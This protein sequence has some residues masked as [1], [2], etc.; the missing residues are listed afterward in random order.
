M[1]LLADENFP[2]PAVRALRSLGHDVAYAKETMR[3]APDRAVLRSAQAEGRV[4][5]TC[6]KDFGELAFAARL[7]A[8]CGVILFRLGGSSPSQ[9]NERMVRV[10]TGRDDWAGNF[11]VVTDTRVR[12]RP[13]PRRPVARENKRGR[14]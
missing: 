7:P 3:G 13:I 14:G 9:D 6:D 5:L 10:L 8:Q 12:L 1:R 4:L 2:G 11:A